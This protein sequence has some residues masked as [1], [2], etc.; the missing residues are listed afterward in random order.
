MTE[1]VEDIVIVGAGIAGLTTAGDQELS[2]ESSESL[3][4]SGSAI[5]LWTN[6]WKALDAVGIADSPRQ[7]HEIIERCV[8]RKLLLEA[9][10]TELPSGTIRKL[11]SVELGV[12][13]KLSGG[14][15]L[16]FKKPVFSGRSGMRGCA[17]YKGSHGFEPKS[18]VFGKGIRCVSTLHF[19]T[20]FIP[21]IS[22]LV[23]GELED[24]P[25][26]MKQFVLSNGHVPDQLKAV[27][28]DTPKTV[29]L[30]KPLRYRQPWEVLWGNISKGGVC[31][32]GDA[33]HPMTP[34]IG[35]G[36]CHLWKTVL[37]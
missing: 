11:N 14:E 13:V 22:L 23:D 37:F 15:R 25:A 4:V 17:D 3:K 24:N 30:Q 21:E 35:Q 31:V 28:Q 26:K 6:A 20:F 16:G 32:A 18:C 27:V 8:K 10:E 19:L 12:G 5:L 34:D 29:S 1:V 2:M 7:Q 9:L 36:G 33:L